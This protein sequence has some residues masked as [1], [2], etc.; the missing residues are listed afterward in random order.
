MR[1]PLRI[2]VLECDT[3]LGKTKSKYGSYG[4]VFSALLE[5]GADALGCPDIVS[6]TRG[7]DISH[8]DIVNKPDTYPKPEDI[9][10]VLITGSSS[11][12]VQVRSR[13]SENVF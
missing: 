12:L 9:D 11:L 3:P 7:L 8:W 4:G 1:P 6:S 10:A 2:A 13:N 5:A